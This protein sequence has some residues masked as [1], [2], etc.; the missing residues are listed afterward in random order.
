[1]RLQEETRALTERHH[2]GRADGAAEKRVRR[3]RANQSAIRTDGAREPTLVPH[4]GAQSSAFFELDER[5]ETERVAL[6][7]IIT[8]IEPR[9]D[10]QARAPE[11]VRAEA[12]VAALDA[13]PE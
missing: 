10:V 13:R 1:G 5:A 6:R 12:L 8:Q 3:D 9:R 11:P 2:D 7:F 4:F